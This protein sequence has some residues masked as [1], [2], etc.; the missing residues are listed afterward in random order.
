VLVTLGPSSA[1]EEMVKALTKEN[2]YLFRINLSHT[3][4]E[5]VEGLI[6]MVRS[7]ADV[8][9]SL[10]SEGAQI[11]NQDI[12]GGSVFYTTGDS[13]K[14]HLMTLLLFLQQIM[15]LV[16]GERKNPG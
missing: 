2:I 10:D 3:P 16:M 6:K 9:I 5:K 12:K 11:R 8:P 14:I 13:I 15:V 4:L 1:N 7:W